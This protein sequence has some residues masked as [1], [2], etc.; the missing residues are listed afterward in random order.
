MKDVLSFPRPVETLEMIL[1][2]ILPF[3]GDV[4]GVRLLEQK[5]KTGRIRE[6]ISV[7]DEAFL[8]LVFDNSLVVWE[9]EVKNML[10]V[11]DQT[12]ILA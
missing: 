10:S 3:M 6:Y 8:L 1:D 9:D 5:L 2:M 4:V 7:S 12:T 11:A